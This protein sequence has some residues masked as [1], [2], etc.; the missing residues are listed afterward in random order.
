MESLDI[1]DLKIL[2]NPNTYESHMKIFK[3][4]VDT[5]II[6]IGKKRRYLLSKDY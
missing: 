2:G 6:T 3:S 1:K 5:S 4:K